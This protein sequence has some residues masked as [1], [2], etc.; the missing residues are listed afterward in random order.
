MS[1]YVY[2][3]TIEVWMNSMWK[4]VQ[5]ILYNTMIEHRFASL[6]ASVDCRSLIP[7]WCMRHPARRQSTHSV[8]IGPRA[9]NADFQWC[10]TVCW[11]LVENRWLQHKVASTLF[12]ASCHVRPPTLATGWLVCG[13]LKCLGRS[14]VMLNP[15]D[16][17]CQPKFW[18][19]G[20]GLPI[21]NLTPGLLQVTQ[22]TG[23]RR[24]CSACWQVKT[25]N[26][27]E[28]IWDGSKTVATMLFLHQDR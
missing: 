10:S 1:Y 15:H 18:G 5:G 14:Q 4:R 7:F 22:L 9:Q 12:A 21:Q 2:L 23:A 25:D 8:S 17:W 3:S 11:Y 13:M 19:H 26:E 27:F 6:L 24:A 20:A 28:W 16:P